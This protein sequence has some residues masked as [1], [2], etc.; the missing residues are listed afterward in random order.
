MKA[1][2]I[3][4]SEPPKEDDSSEHSAET[5]SLRLGNFFDLLFKIDKRNHPELYEPNKSGASSN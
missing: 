1:N 3:K 5:H 4:T 2:D